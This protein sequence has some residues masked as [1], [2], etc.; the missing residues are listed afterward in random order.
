[1]EGEMVLRVLVC[2]F[3]AALVV[4][5]RAET[6]N[7]VHAHEILPASAGIDESFEKKQRRRLIAGWT[8]LGAGLGIGFGAIAAQKRGIGAAIGVGALGAATMLTGG[9]LLIRRRR[10][11]NSHDETVVANEGSTLV[12]R[13][14]L[15]SVTIAGRF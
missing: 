2:V 14:G 11:R 4:G 10:L 13:P 6:G 7:T 1:M 8:M 5:L 12:I 9:A 15:G 3:L